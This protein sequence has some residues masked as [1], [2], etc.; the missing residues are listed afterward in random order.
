MFILLKLVLTYFFL[1]FVVA[2]FLIPH[3]N[4]GE[5][6][7]PESIPDSMKKKINELRSQASN[8]NDFLKQAYEYIGNRYRSE[9]LNTIMKF[10]YLFYSVDQIWSMSGYIPCTQS[11]YLM[12]IF[13]VESG[14]FK[15]SEIRK[16][17]VFTNLILHQY[18]EVNIDGK[19]VPV[20]VGEKQRG[21]PIGKYLKRFG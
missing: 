20:D 15:N 21:L 16:Q 17:F 3:L 13:L 6:K 19:W 1:V 2:R 12:R 9:R 18:L 8:K 4:F 5:D 14:Y 7:M 10:S 11:S